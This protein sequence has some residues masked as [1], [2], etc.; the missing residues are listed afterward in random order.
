MI[1]EPGDEQRRLLFQKAEESGLLCRAGGEAWQS[2]LA[3]QKAVKI[4]AVSS[5]FQLGLL[6][7]LQGHPERWC[8][9]FFSKQLHLASGNLSKVS[10][11]H[12][13]SHFPCQ[14]LLP[15]PSPVN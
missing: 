8:P 9:Q 6:S 4:M 7:G 2:G 1:R 5:Y 15:F 14:E 11:S 3:W 10:A 13:H 12:W